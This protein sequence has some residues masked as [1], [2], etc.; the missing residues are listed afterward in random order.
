MTSVPT[1]PTDCLS[2]V[3]FGPGFGESIA[4]RVPP[5]RW[6][7][8]DSLHGFVNGST[9]VNPVLR[10]LAQYADEEPDVVVLTHSHLDHAVGFEAYTDAWPEATYG[11]VPAFLPSYRDV[12]RMKDLEAARR[13]GAAEHAV[14]AID[15]VWSKTADPGRRWD[16]APGSYRMVGEA[17]VIAHGPDKTT[18]ARALV[19]PPRDLNRLSA[20]LELKWH[21][22]RIILGADLPATG[23]NQLEKKEPPLI[24]GAHD[25]LKVPHHG[26]HKA[27]AKGFGVPPERTRNWTLTPWRLGGKATPIF[28]DNYGVD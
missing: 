9:S 15:N 10:L 21:D 19:K 18:V 6:L 12:I 11:C 20:P 14:A 28:D 8:V 22:A 26:S 23:W 17:R 13:R 7:I 3:L 4:V 16:L 5:G 1:L 24:A 27:I 25:G 2:V